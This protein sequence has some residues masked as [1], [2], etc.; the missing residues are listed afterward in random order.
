VA[1]PAARGDGY[2]EYRDEPKAEEHRNLP[3]F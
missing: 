3:N 2:G 1:A